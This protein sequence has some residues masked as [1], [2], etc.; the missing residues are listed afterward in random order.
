MTNATTKNLTGLERISS[1]LLSTLDEGIF[2]SELSRHLNE[3]VCAESVKV[4][5][6]LEDQTPKLVSVNFEASQAS[7]ESNIS[8]Y[9]MKNRRPYFSNSVESDPLLEEEAKSGL[10]K[11]LCVP[12][13]HEGVVIAT[14][15]FASNDEERKFSRKD[16]TAILE[17]I[18]EL[19]SP[20]A[21]MKMYLSAMALNE[22]LQQQLNEQKSA[23]VAQVREVSQA[24]VVNEGTIVGKSASMTK[25]LDLAEKASQLE[26]NVLIEGEVG[27]GKLMIARRIHCRSARKENAFV[28]VDCNKDSSMLMEELFGRDDVEGALEKSINGTIVLSNID[29]L[30]VSSQTKLASFLKTRVAVRN[31]GTTPFRSNTRVMALTSASLI[32]RIEEGTFRDDLFFLLNTVT[33]EVPALRNR[34]EDIESLLN[35]Y[36]NMNKSSDEMKT[37]APSA[38]RTLIEYSWSSNVRELKSTMEKAFILAD[39]MIVDENHLPERILEGEQVVEEESEEEEYKFAEMTLNDL[40]K[41]HICMTLEFLGGNKTKTAK[42]LGITV[43]TLYNKLHS[44]DMIDAKEA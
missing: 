13:S 44:Y 7:E 40:E 19:S 4:F 16:I 11:I 18:Q 39:G 28:V 22:A 30:N 41:K 32:E 1:I 23:P 24:H 43:K 38:L 5:R 6:A 10:K 33:L 42:A 25:L 20:I 34:V 37:I 31:N 9:V 12:V 15:Q 26:S 17:Q 29:K 21:N 14:V 35:Y 2:F 3:S 8:S 27:T 36:L